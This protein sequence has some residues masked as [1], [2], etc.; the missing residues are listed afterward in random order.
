M[1]FKDE[2]SVVKNEEVEKFLEV[3]AFVWMAI[4][5]IVVFC[6]KQWKEK[7]WPTGPTG[8]E[9]LDGM[10]RRDKDGHGK[11]SYMVSISTWKAALQMLMRLEW[12]EFWPESARAKHR[13]FQAKSPISGLVGVITLRDARKLGL[14]VKVRNGSHGEE[15]YTQSAFGY[16]ETNIIT[17]IVEEEMMVAWFPGDETYPMP[18]VEQGETPA[19]AMDPDAWNLDWAVKLVRLS[20]EEQAELEK[21]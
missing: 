13:Y 10:S 3:Q 11:G 19:S 8:E 5:N 7:L 4:I 12:A 1:E 16:T 2:E 20:P 17:L 15:L 18:A 6:M 9:Y 21:W 14:P